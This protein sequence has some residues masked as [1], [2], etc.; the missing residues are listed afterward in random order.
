MMDWQDIET[1]P[2]DGTL[3]DLWA[4]GQRFPDCHFQ[5]YLAHAAPGHWR[6]STTGM[7]KQGYSLFENITH[8]MPLPSPPVQS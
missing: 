3:V 1:A 8:W 2:K 7:P 4:D 6:Q 5:E